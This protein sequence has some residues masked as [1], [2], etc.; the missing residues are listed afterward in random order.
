MQLGE[1]YSSWQPADHVVLMGT[2]TYLFARAA[3]KKGIDSGRLVFAEDLGVEEL[4]E[5]IVGLV[6][7]TA[8]VMGM[9]NIGGEGLPLTRYF[10]NRSHPSELRS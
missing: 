10:R 7:G 1:D 3:M 8:L 9:G 2:G 4:F 5:Q 6:N